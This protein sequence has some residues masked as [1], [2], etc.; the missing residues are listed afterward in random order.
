MRWAFVNV[1][2]TEIVLL[3]SF[4]VQSLLFDLLNS[5]QELNALIDFGSAVRKDINELMFFKMQP[6]QNR[7]KMR[8]ILS[9][10]IGVLDV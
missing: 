4:F 2:L 5:L 3:V 1:L 8:F 6:P 10:V 9:Q 7:Q